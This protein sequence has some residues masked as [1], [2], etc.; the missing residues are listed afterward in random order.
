MFYLFVKIVTI[1]MVCII[2]SL[3]PGLSQNQHVT[4]VWQSKQKNLFNW[5]FCLFKYAVQIA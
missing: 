3:M 1:N 5:L 4:H 2:S